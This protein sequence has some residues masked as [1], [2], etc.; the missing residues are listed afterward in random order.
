MMSRVEARPLPQKQSDAFDAPGLVALSDA[1]MVASAYA[2]DKLGPAVGQDAMMVLAFDGMGVAP[3][4]RA[5]IRI[6]SS[7]TGPP[8][9]MAITP[10]GRYAIVIETRGPRPASGK[11]V[12]RA[13][14]SLARGIT[15]VDLRD[16]AH[17]TVAQRL[18]GPRVAA[19]VS[20]SADG[21]LVAVAVLPIGDGGTTLLW[22]YRFIGG[23]LAEGKALQIPGW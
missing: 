6:R 7:V 22:I 2:D 17:P 5:T 15:V 8:A 12:G 10:D 14:L 3:T 23:R 11:D 18:L 4:S 19:T 13:K 9:P 16:L 1:D 21:T 20:V